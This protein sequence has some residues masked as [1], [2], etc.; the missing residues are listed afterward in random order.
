MMMFGSSASTYGAESGAAVFSLINE[1]TATTVPAGTSQ[2][3][4]GLQVEDF[5]LLFRCSIQRSCHPPRCNEGSPRVCGQQR[6]EPSSSH[7]AWQAVIPTPLASAISSSGARVRP[8]LRTDRFAKADHPI[9][10]SYRS[11]QCLRTVFASVSGED[12]RRRL[13]LIGSG[14]GHQWCDGTSRR[15]PRRCRARSSAVGLFHQLV[16]GPLFTGRAFPVR[17]KRSRGSKAEGR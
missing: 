11:N 10:M 4:S 9:S 14:S 1:V 5:T 6:L 15:S 3:F 2:T 7:F 17:C 12:R 16:Q 8:Q 13:R